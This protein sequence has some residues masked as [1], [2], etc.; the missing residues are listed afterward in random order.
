MMRH[1]RC[2]VCRT[3]STRSR[4]VERV[5]SKT[6]RTVRRSVRR[7]CADVRRR[8]S[9]ERRVATG[10][11]RRVAVVVADVEVAA[12]K[13]PIKW[14]CCGTDAV[15]FVHCTKLVDTRLLNT[16]MLLVFVVRR[17]CCCGW[18]GPAFS[19]SG[20]YTRHCQPDVIAVVGHHCWHSHW[21]WWLC[22]S[23][24]HPQIDVLS[25]SV[26]HTQSSLQLTL[27]LIT[28]HNSGHFTMQ[29]G[30][31]STVVRATILWRMAKLGIPALRNP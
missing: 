23:R 14:R 28:C 9:L 19:C 27:D 20:V 15:M 24:R 3:C 11:L 4:Q 10:I 2:I 21:Y 12:D 25:A 1:V 18:R 22:V 7:H 5:S 8:R 29:P 17:A 31:A 6:G 16:F 26:S 30:S 13:P